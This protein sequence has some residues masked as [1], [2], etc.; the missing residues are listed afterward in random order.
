MVA[1]MEELVEI[2]VHVLWML[3]MS[4][5]PLSRHEPIVEADELL[6]SG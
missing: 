4:A 1:G 5:L 3:L 6:L 2:E